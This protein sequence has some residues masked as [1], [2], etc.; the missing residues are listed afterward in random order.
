MSDF[1]SVKS[2][3][4]ITAAEIEKALG[5]YFEDDSVTGKLTEA[6]GYTTMAG[7]KRIRGFL[8]LE[9]CRMLGGKKEDAMPLAC[10]V[11]M[12]HAASLIH[13][14]LPA[15]DND[16]MRRGKPS[17]H[18][19]YG[20]D[21]ALLAG[22]ALWVYAYE[23]IASSKLS[24][25]KKAE[26]VLALSRSTGVTEGIMGGQYLD[27]LAEKVKP[28]KAGLLEIHKRKTSALINGAVQ[29]GCI[30]AGADRAA[31][32]AAKKY[33]EGIGLAFQIIDDVL[34]VTGT[35]EELGKPIGSDK[36]EEK[37]T[38]MSFMSVQEALSEAAYATE[39]GINAIRDYAGSGLLTD[40]ADYL[41][42]RRS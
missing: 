16:D 24:N 39:Q 31:R 8:T 14:D 30:A 32:E 2:S 7:G 42:H 17:C 5:G 33:A 23:I 19:V 4:S 18:I 6:M 26:A 15:M 11:E 9:F 3:L 20:E 37:T 34:D 22:D 36:N 29:L 21:N 27:L 13:D 1:F 35:F 40:L 25:D 41:L 38:F 10:A 28:D 12:T